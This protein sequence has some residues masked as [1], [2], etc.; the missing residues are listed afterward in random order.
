MSTLWRDM[1]S[2]SSGRSDKAGKNL[3]KSRDLRKCKTSSY[4]SLNHSCIKEKHTWYWKRILKY[5]NWGYAYA[6]RFVV[7]AKGLDMFRLGTIATGGNLNPSGNF[8]L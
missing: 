2:P 4:T 7:S 1:L 3:T 6:N 5:S 8:V